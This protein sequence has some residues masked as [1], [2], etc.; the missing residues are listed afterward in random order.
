MKPHIE[1]EIM[2]ESEKSL[3]DPLSK[4]RIKND[5]LELQKLGEALIRLPECQLVKVTLPDE[6]LA[7]VRLAHTLKTNE[8]KRRHLQYIGKIMR[9]IDCEQIRAEIKVITA[10]ND[11]RTAQF[12]Q[13]EQWREKLIE[14]DD[15]VLQELLQMYPNGDRQHMRQLIRKAKQERE[16]NKKAGSE[17]ALFRYLQELFA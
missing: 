16:N 11:K 17:K 6:L 8:A 9:Q 5:M 1:E 2:P 3:P 4:T 13:V 12:H 7:A 15:G 14:G 10:G